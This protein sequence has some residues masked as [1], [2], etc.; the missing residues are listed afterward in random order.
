M[1]GTGEGYMTYIGRSQFLLQRG[2]NVADVLVFTG[3]SSPND[4][5]LMPEITSLGY[6][7]DLIGVSKMMSLTVKDGLIYTPAGG[8]Y[9]VIVLPESSWMTP[10]M[11]MKI[12]ELAK[13]GALIIGPKPQKSPSLRNYPLCDEQVVR[14][15]EKLWDKNLVKD[16]SIVDILKREKFSPDFS[17]EAG[18]NGS[19]RFIHRLMTEL[20]FIL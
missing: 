6:D 9:R 15:T 17:T 5:T 19:I 7:Y 16:C 1:V 20:I 18:L 2:R 11:L 14:L 4:A 8:E 13:S 3:E 10:E 12:E